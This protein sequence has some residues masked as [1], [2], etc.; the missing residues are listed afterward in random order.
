M[1]PNAAWRPGFLSNPALR[2]DLLASIGLAA[3]FGAAVGL[4]KD[5][6][7]PGVYALLPVLGAVLMIV[8]PNS[9]VI[10][11]GDAPAQLARQPGATKVTS[12]DTIPPSGCDGPDCVVGV[13]I[14]SNGIDLI[15]SCV[16]AGLLFRSQLSSW[17]RLADS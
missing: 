1:A 10:V 2:E 16:A 4:G 11:V 9:L 6:L 7:F 14:G 12:I 17:V 15:L 5:S 3:I 13:G 8:S